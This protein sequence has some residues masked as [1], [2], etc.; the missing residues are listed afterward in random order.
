VK[1][2]TL[3]DLR[4]NIPVFSQRYGH[5]ATLVISSRAFKLLGGDL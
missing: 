1:L 3:R 2:H 5:C 4:G